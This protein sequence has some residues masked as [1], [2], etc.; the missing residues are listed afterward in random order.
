M[1]NDSLNNN[2]SQ[3]TQPTSDPLLSRR[4][5]RRDHRTWTDETKADI[6][7]RY[8]EGTLVKDIADRMDLHLI[9][10]GEFLRSVGVCTT[11]NARANDLHCKGLDI[12]LRTAVMQDVE[13]IEFNAY[14]VRAMRVEKSLRR[15][16]LGYGVTYE[17]A[18]QTY[19]SFKDM[20]LVELVCHASSLD[21]F[22]QGSI[23]ERMIE[24]LQGLIRKYLDASAE[25]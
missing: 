1:K 5:S 23:R 25:R 20:T 15:I 18:R 4:S 8:G 3:L 22:P 16:A 17:V 12:E 14:E 2:K 6:I 7:R 9:S 11:T 21:A 10:V 13:P 24:D 19:I